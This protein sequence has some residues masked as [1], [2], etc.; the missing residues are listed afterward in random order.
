MSNRSNHA[1]PYLVALMATAVLDPV[2]MSAQDAKADVAAFV[3]ART[4]RYGAVAQQIWDLAEVG[5]REAES[6]GLLAATLEDEGFDVEMGVAGMPTAFVARWRQGDGPVI[7]ILAEYDALPGLS[8]A[9]TPERAAVSHQVAG[10]ACGH[11]LFGTGSAAAAAATKTWMQRSGQGGEIRVY[12]T[13]AE[14]GGAGKVYM[15][16]EGLFDDVD[17]V[18]HWHAGDR[19]EA[20]VYTTLANKS[21]T[22]RF[23]GLSAHAAAA[24]ELG[25]S[26]LDGVEAM[27]H[28]VNLMREHVDQETRIHYVITNGGAAPNVVPDAAEVYYFV[29]HPDPAEVA[30]VFE[31]VELAAEGAAM[32]TGTTVEVEVLHGIYNLL[33]NVALQE[34][35]HANLQRVGGVVYDAEE[36]RFAEALGRS[37]PDDAP[38]LESAEQVQPFTVMEGAGSW[39]TDVADV[40]WV[41]PTAGLSTATWIPGTATHSWQAVAAGGT[42]IGEKGM[43]VAAKALAMTA[44]DLLTDPS[45]IEHA[46]LEYRERLPDGWSYEPLLGDRP[47]PLDYRS[48]GGG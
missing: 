23:S 35:V 36:R 28:M 16:R 1:L 40:S 11:H 17:I 7:G 44:V 43:I 12:G 38:P 42:T 46:T 3:E 26:A 39:S 14:E 24:P 21:A 13:P 25:R 5:Y 29:R 31:R 33:P 27:N 32:G 41:V 48:N 30:A 9:R 34:A 2:S 15:V 6:A 18:L 45:L 22:F 8:Q 4:E 10:H 47:P 37:L 19:N 20:G